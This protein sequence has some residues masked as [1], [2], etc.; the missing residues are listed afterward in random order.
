MDHGRGRQFAR[1]AQPAD[2]PTEIIIVGQLVVQPGEAPDL[3]QH[4]ARERN[5]RSEAGFSHLQPHAHDHVRHELVVYPHGRQLRPHPV[6]GF[7]GIETGDET[8]AWPLQF[9]HHAL[10]VVTAYPDVAVGHHDDLVRNRGRHVDQVGDLAV[11]A[12]N[13]PIDHQIDVAVRIGA[14]EIA[15]DG[16][17]AVRGVVHAEKELDG[18]GVGLFTEAGQVLHQTLLCAMQRLQEGDRR[19]RR[20]RS[21]TGRPAHVVEGGPGGNHCKARTR[22]RHDDQ[23]CA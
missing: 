12:V 20:G 11:L 21:S 5:G 14:L 22:Q 7:A 2:R 1:V 9:R 19:R 16:D 10:Q 4:A 15:H 13:A 6:A 3:G 18:T 17:G 23:G 8:H